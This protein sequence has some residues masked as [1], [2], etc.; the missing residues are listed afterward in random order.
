MKRAISRS[1][2]LTVCFKLYKKHSVLKNKFFSFF[3]CI[4]MYIQNI[5]K[6]Y[7]KNHLKIKYLNCNFY[8]FSIHKIFDEGSSIYSSKKKKKTLP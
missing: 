6:I 4:F 7:L 2:K 1:K 5:I 3:Y 8:I